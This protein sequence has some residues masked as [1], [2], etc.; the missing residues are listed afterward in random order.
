MIEQS[1][2]GVPV[3]LIR[4]PE[5]CNRV[6]LSRASIY[7]LIDAGKFPRQ[8]KLAANSVA[9]VDRE[10]DAWIAERIAA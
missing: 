5:V 6:G 3:R 8:R 1:N 4:L 7:V 2:A 9:W 10:V